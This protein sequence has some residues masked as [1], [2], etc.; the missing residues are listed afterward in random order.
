MGEAPM[1]P[2][3]AS[4]KPKDAG[5]QHGLRAGGE[6]GGSGFQGRGLCDSADFGPVHWLEFDH[7]GGGFVFEAVVAAGGIDEERIF[8]DGAVVLT[9]FGSPV[10]EG[11]ALEG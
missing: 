11:H 6:G 2:G 5:W 9:A 10:F 3:I 7:P 8:D 4:I 1:P